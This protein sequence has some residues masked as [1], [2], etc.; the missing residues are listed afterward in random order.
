MV[1]LVQC[2]KSSQ[3]LKFSQNAYLANTQGFSKY[4]VGLF[5]DFFWVKA[6]VTGERGVEEGQVSGPL[7]ANSPCLF[8]PLSALPSKPILTKSCRVIFFI[9]F[10]CVFLLHILEFL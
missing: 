7:S 5:S 9:I 4:G 10:F 2:A 1:I 8:S 3:W 6:L